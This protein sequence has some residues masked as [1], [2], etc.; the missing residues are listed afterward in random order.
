V[1]IPLVV[2]ELP[3]YPFISG[4]DRAGN[5]RIGGVRVAF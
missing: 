1:R 4:L 3:S 5:K 2:G